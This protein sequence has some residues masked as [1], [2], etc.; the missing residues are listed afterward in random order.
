MIPRLLIPFAS[1]TPSGALRTRL[2][3]PAVAAVQVHGAAVADSGACRA[4]AAAIHSGSPEL[5]PFVVLDPHSPRHAGAEDLRPPDPDHLALDL[6]S[7]G[8]D[9]EVTLKVMNWGRRVAE[10]GIDLVLSPRLDRS[11]YPLS[12]SDVAARLLAA[13]TEA[14]LA[15]GLIACA[16][17]YPSAGTVDA[18]VDD[19]WAPFGQAV[20]H[21]LETLHLADELARDAGELRRTVEGLR[22]LA[23][24]LVLVGPV[25]ADAAQA[26]ASLDAGVDLV[27]LS[28]SMAAEEIDALLAELDDV[29]T[30]AE[31]L[32]DFLRQDWLL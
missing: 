26:R 9:F 8:E 32:V 11:Q 10:L 30:G 13:W 4:L 23:D 24:D 21:G 17:P 29:G 3:H 16:G 2:H 18:K 20:A 22:A 5:P 6:A 31:G 25:V 7:G 12:G 15:S 1:D 19:T 14:L 27:R 28:G